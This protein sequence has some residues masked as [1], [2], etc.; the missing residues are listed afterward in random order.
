MSDSAIIITALE[1]L[2]P[3]DGVSYILLLLLIAFLGY[4]IYLYKKKGGENGNGDRGTTPISGNVQGIHE[5]YLRRFQR[6]EES[7]STNQTEI[8]A[9]LRELR[10]AFSSIVHERGD[11][12]AQ[13]GELKGEI[14]TL[15]K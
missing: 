7:I 2:K 5:D 15:L 4:L 8:K 10:N 6:I 1:W 14:K 12:M 13:I 3:K 9:E 11:M